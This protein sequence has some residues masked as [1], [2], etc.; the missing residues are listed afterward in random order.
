MPSDR[1]ISSLVLAELYDADD[2]AFLDRLLQH[3]G[4]FKPYLGLIER[5][6]KDPRPWARRLKIEFATRENLH[7]DA[8]IIFKR[9]F[10]Q[11]WADRD[12]E[13]M[14]AFM[15]TLDTQLRRK[16]A[17]Q[18]RFLQGV[19]LTNEVLR[20]PRAHQ[21][22][23]F[24]APTTH[25]LRRRAWRYFRLMGF[26]DT[27]A[28]V[29]AV[30]GALVRYREEHVRT[31]ANLLDNWGLMHA[32]FGKSPLLAFNARH[33]N[34]APS[35]RLGDL[36]AAPMFERHWALP[37]S[38]PVLLDILLRAQC[39]P[40]RVWAI[41]L[42]R[43]LHGAA[44]PKID[45]ATLLRLIDHADTD[46]ATFAA[47]LLSDAQTVSSFPMTTWIAL[48]ATRNQTVVASVVEA[49][50]KHVNFDR[51]TVA[52]AVDLAIRPAVPVAVLGLD[53]LRGKTIRPVTDHIELARLATAQASAA[54]VAIAAF[55]LPLLNSP[56]V[57]RIDEV[58]AFFDSGLATLR[59]GA[60]AALIDQSPADT[61][62]AFWARLFESPYDDVRITLVDRLKRR[63]TLPGATS[64][65]LASLWQSVLLNIHRGGR[66]KLS[67]LKQISDYITRV[68]QDARS[69][70]SVLVIAIRS[71]RPPEARHGLAAIVSAVERNDALLA[72]V[73]TLLPELQLDV[74]A[75]VR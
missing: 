49:F 2:G 27:T 30:A 24:S 45:A 75:G 38:F 65:T 32:C 71:V 50:R 31:G 29:P 53:L 35:G 18:Y 21:S 40:V 17:T 41:Q 64:D 1:P 20:L 12:H 68:P 14:A 52:Q 73:K 23:M 72:D 43:R 42:L 55:A 3:R 7:T 19:I 47:E 6:K 8:R 58:T 9:L 57:Y 61:D 22:R 28:Y 70:L 56:G 4:N 69:L 60:F 59:E 74:A 11:A 62:P 5:W 48:L 51:V 26:T 66:A 67:A 63:A 54:G 36:Q 44:L 39:R 46:V 10:K 34:L 37:E 33:T 16:R 13:L 25:Y 15:V